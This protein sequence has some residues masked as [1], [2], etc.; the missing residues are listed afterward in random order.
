MRN[1]ISAG[2]FLLLSIQLSG[3]KVCGTPHS[4]PLYDL[5]VPS[6]R[7][8]P[9]EA[10]LSIPVVVHIVLPEGH[11]QLPDSRIHSQI[12]GLNRDFNKMNNDISYVVSPFHSSIGNAGIEFCLASKD[13]NGAYTNGITR[14]TTD[15]SNLGQHIFQDGRRSVHYD[16]L[17]GKDAWDTERY[18][19]IWVAEMTSF[20]GRSSFPDMGPPEEDGIVI[21]PGFFGNLGMPRPEISKGRTLV[22]EV[23]HYL[24]LVHPWLEDGCETDD[25]LDDTPLQNAPYFGCPDPLNSMSCQSMDMTQNFMQYGS[26]ECLLFF[27]KD[28]VKLMRMVLNQKRPDLLISGSLLSC[29]DPVIDQKRDL[30]YDPVQRSVRFRE[31]DPDQKLTFRLFDMSGKLVTVSR[32]SGYHIPTLDMNYFPNGVYIVQVLIEGQ[33]FTKKILKYD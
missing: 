4:Q 8:N 16:V 14:T 20:S 32:F 33:T 3:Q 24:G 15:I 31:I 28:Q 7:A 23:G 27:T 19:N 29:A 5:D 12:D 13:P 26:D 22:H 11:P 1:F 10:V 25:G 18:L 21:D 2:L 6:D 17:G 9:R 30:F